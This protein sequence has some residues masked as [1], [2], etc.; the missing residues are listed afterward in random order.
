MEKSQGQVE[1]RGDNFKH[2][3]AMQFNN[4]D[5]FKSAGANSV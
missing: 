3:T 5:K 4:K 1:K 2:I